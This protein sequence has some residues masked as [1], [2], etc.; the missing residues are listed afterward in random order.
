[1]SWI[2]SFLL[3]E[4]RRKYLIVQTYFLLLRIIG[5]LWAKTLFILRILLKLG[6]PPFHL[7]IVFLTIN[8]SLFPFIFLMTIHKLR[9]L[10]LLSKVLTITLIRIIVISIIIRVS[11]IIQTKNF[12]LVLLFSSFL[13]RCWIVRLG[14]FNYLLFLIYWLRYRIVFILWILSLK[15]LLLRKINLKQRSFTNFGWILIS[16]LPPFRIFWLKIGFIFYLGKTSI[17]LRWVFLISVVFRLRAYYRIFQ[18]RTFWSRVAV[19]KISPFIGVISTIAF[20]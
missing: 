13:Q 9:P 2:F 12:L 1:M 16:G 20:I 14:I 17:F 10:G 6:I 7:W 8:I 4:R 15:S 19:V 3:K 5:L 11:I 18:N